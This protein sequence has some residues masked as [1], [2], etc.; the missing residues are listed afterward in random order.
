MKIVVLSDTHG[1]LKENVKKYLRQCDYVIHAGDI[2]SQSVYHELKTLNRNLYMVRGNCDRGMWAS[3]LPE[4]LAFRIDGILFYLIHDR[5][6]LMARPEP[7]TNIFI[8]GHTHKYLLGEHMGMATL[9]P[10]S[11]TQPRGGMPPTCA[12]ITTQNGKYSIERVVV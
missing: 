2:G 6:S 9:N 8:S 1:I 7:Q 4:T 11:C 3:V 12:V 10:G 5:T